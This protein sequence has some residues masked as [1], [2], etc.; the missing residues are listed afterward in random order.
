MT[1]KF[2][3]FSNNY[4]TTLVFVNI[5]KKL[6]HKKYIIVLYIIY[7]ILAKNI[8]ILLSKKYITKLYHKKYIIVLYIIYK[9]LAKNILILLSKKYI[10]KLYHKKYI[11]VLYIIF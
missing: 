4:I 9:I 10:T 7:K 3:L 11:I 8:L 1:N 2:Y 6:Y 5:S